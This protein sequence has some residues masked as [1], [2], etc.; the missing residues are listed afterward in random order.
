MSH[1]VFPSN[2]T[3]IPSLP[4]RTLSNFSKIPVLGV[5]NFDS[6]GCSIATVFVGAG[7]KRME[8]LHSPSQVLAPIFL[9]GRQ[10]EGIYTSRCRELRVFERLVE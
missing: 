8:L 1:P 6:H 4:D 3:G 7:I 9:V 10:T 5:V 2:G